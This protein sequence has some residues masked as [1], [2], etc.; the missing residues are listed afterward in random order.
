VRLHKGSKMT[1]YELL[2]QQIKRMIAGT[3]RLSKGNIHPLIMQEI[4]KYIIQITLQ[5]TN[6]N[7]VAT[8]RVLGIARSTLYRKIRELGIENADK[9]LQN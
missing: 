9:I 3:G 1:L 8:A 7:Y 5:E 6:N 4:E 2:R